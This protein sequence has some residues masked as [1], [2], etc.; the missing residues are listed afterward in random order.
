[1]AE[2]GDMHPNSESERFYNEMSAK[3]SA[4][5]AAKRQDAVFTLFGIGLKLMDRQTIL[6]LRDELLQRF[7]QSEA[8]RNMSTVLLEMIEGHLMLRDLAE[9]SNPPHEML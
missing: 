4:L 6:E 1:M 8:D 3:I 9:G 7:P 5:P 2:I